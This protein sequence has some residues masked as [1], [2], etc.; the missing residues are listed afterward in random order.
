LLPYIGYSQAA[1]LAHEMKNNS[2]G[3]LEA[4]R[5]LNIIA[6]EKLL[7]I[8][9]PGNLLKEGFNLEDIIEQDGKR[10]GE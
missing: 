5:R 9:Q 3:I 10:K 6:E 7:Q 8:I 4:N 2:L 1:R